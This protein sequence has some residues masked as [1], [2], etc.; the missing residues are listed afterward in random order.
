MRP[1]YGSLFT[2]VGGFDLGFDRA[3]ME[4]LWQCEIDAN[5]RKLLHRKWPKAKLY[6]DITTIKASELRRVD[7][8]CGGSPCQDLSVAG[9]RAGMAGERSGL[10]REMVRVCKRIRPRVILWENVDGAF[11][12][13][14]GRDFAAV[15]RAF[16]GLQV[17]VPVD[18]WG[19]AGFIKTPF[20]AWRWNCA[21]RLFDAQYFGVAQRRRRVFLVASFGDGSC[22]EVLFEP[23]SLRGDSPPSRDAA[24]RIAP[25]VSA[26]TE[27]GG[28]LG[29]DF[30]L[31]GGLIA[32]VAHPL[33]AEGRDASEDGTGRGTPIIPIAFSCKD[34]GA[35]AGALAPTL[36]AM[37]HRDS[38]MNGGGQVAIA[39]QEVGKRT[40]VS[41]DDKRCGLG[42]AK[43]GDPMFT[44][45]AGAQ[46]GVAV[47]FDTTQITSPE[48]RC[49][50]QPGDP[51]HPLSAQAHAP[52][53]A[54]NPQ[55]GGK[56]TTLGYDEHT[57]AT[58]SRSQLPAVAIAVRGRDGGGTA[59]MG[60]DKSFALRA[61]QGGGDKP[62][63]L[64]SMAVRRLTPTECERLMAF[65]D[66]H[67][68]GFAD[69][70]RYKMCGN[71]VVSNCAHWL[72]RRIV[73]AIATTSM[74]VFS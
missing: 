34:H 17:E 71:A 72:G 55:A 62:H 49:N 70:V 39:I 14:D 12:S 52:A 28:G 60:D 6:D 20:P 4:C 1:T 58:L 40:G 10:F 8:I 45:Q 54:F 3:G 74:P 57:D 18:G 41:T 44:L 43:A 63:V 47:A 56:Q 11:S 2:G 69:T 33:S 22:A 59:E 31:D 50:P 13:N 16:T 15:L 9:K 68:A 37:G 67:T 5:C 27:G 26:R 24:E 42:I 19:R 23:E 29:T 61:S 51:C 25:T 53:I 64:A 65:P 48:N 7:V 30:D 73:R 66:G 21:W 32:G 35:D 36:R 46:H 38:H